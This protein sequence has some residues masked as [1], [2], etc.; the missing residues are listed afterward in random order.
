M[1]SCHEV[2]RELSN[3][4]DRDVDPALRA[5]IEA[6]LSQCHRCSMLLDTTRKTLYIV[7]DDRVFEVPGDFSRRLH[8]AVAAKIGA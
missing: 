4:I 5:E 6:H 2:L 1:V 3:Y 8:A 7:G